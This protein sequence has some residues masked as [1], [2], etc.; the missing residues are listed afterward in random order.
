MTGLRK[1][2]LVALRWCDVDWTAGEIRVRRNYVRGE[3]GTP[4]SRRSSRS[5]PMADEVGERAASALLDGSSSRGDDDLVFAHPDTGGRCRK[6][7]SPGGSKAL[8]AAGLDDRTSLPRPATHVRHPHGRRRG[9]D[10][11]AAG[12][13]G[14]PHITTTQATPTTRRAPTRRRWSTPP[15]PARRPTRNSTPP[16]VA[17]GSDPTISGDLTKPEIAD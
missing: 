7:T 17:I 15:S 14:P 2:E 6:P 16:V 1:G 10:A 9:A 13:D 8:E 11:H 12:V 4:K 3:F 5:V